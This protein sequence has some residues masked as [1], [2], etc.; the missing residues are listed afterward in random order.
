[1]TVMAA[2]DNSTNNL[3]ST[4]FGSAHPF[5]ESRTEFEL[6]Q[7]KDVGQELNVFR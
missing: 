5:R 7:G 4:R 1:M 6:I 2:A 3:P